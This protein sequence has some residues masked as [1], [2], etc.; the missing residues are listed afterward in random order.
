MNQVTL[1]LAPKVFLYEWMFKNLEKIS[2]LEKDREKAH[3]TT[4]NRH[5]EIKQRFGKN[6]FFPYFRK[7]S[8]MLRYDRRATKLGCPTNFK[9]LQRGPFKD[10]TCKRKNV[11]KLKH[12]EN[13]ILEVPVNGIFLRI[14]H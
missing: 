6:I 5:W 3:G 9:A 8:L 2:R 13:N 10:S 11:Y 1:K 14:F 7:E 4:L 12:M